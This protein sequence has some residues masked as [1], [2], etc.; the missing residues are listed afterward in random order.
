MYLYFGASGAKIMKLLRK[1]HN[2]KRTSK[3][4]PQMPHFTDKGNQW[5]K[6]DNKIDAYMP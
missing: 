3:N 2:I 4:L 6:Y 1:K 5:L